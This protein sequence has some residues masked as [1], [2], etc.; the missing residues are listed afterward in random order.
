M[1]SSRDDRNFSKGY[2]ECIADLTTILI[3]QGS[4][5]MLTWMYDNCTDAPRRAIIAAFI[6]D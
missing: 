2:Q 5:A 4:A 1:T 6:P 3:E